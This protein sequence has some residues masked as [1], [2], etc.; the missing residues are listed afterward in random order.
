MAGAGAA[1]IWRFV[2]QPV[3]GVSR[4]GGSRT[5]VGPAGTHTLRRPQRGG[6]A[7]R[8]AGAL[9]NG[10]RMRG[11]VDVASMQMYARACRGRFESTMSAMHT[12]PGSAVGICI[13]L[14]R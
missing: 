12:Q 4:T 10:S 5:D 9:M 3:G 14:A 2:S 6:R 8:R 7:R 11:T 13:S 1:E